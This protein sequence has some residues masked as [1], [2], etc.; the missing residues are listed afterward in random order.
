MSEVNMSNEEIR[1]EF[2]F[3]NMVRESGS[4]NMFGAAPHLAEVFGL[5]RREARQVLFEW[6]QWVDGGIK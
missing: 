4:I 6:M 5:D 2:A 1:P 3:L